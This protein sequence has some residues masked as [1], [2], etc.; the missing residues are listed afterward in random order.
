M[1]LKKI[2]QNAKNIIMLVL[3]IET[4]CDET[5][6]SLVEIYP[7]KSRKAETSGK[8][9][10]RIKVLSNVVSSQ[11]KLHAKY[12][13]VVPSLAAREHVKNLRAVLELALRTGNRK[14]KDVDLIAV[15]AG[16]GL[17][18]SLLVGTAFARTLAWKLNK[19]I[20]GVN[21]IEGHI[22]SNWL[23]PIAENSKFE[24]QN[25]KKSKTLNLKLVSD[26]G[27]RASDLFPAICLVVSGGHTQL[28]L[29]KGF[30]KYKIV[31][32]TLDDAAGEAFDKIARILG[33]G[34]PGGPAISRHAEKWKSE[35]TSIKSQTNS[36]FQ[37]P[38]IELPRPM[39]NS[40]NFDFSFSGLKTAVLYL[41][42]DLKK[43]LGKDK[44]PQELICQI[45]AEAQQ[46]I[47]DVLVSKTIKAAEEYK[48]KSI[49]LSGGV[50][51]N[52]LLRSELQKN[53]QQK[54]IKY[55]QP[56]AEYTTDNAAMIALAGY[57]KS[58]KESRQA[59]PVT[60]RKAK[61]KESW[62]KVKADAN[63]EI[64]K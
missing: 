30:R 40:K 42:R 25:S 15:T 56:F 21:H 29:M 17:I 23:P 10:D 37:I 8:S 51:A 57:I 33:L 1:K 14:L 41:D 24:I 19:P 55:F 62:Q 47:V 63:W 27:F 60:Q 36:K 20:I 38:K 44:L 26:F 58:L 45:A 6:A 7:A 39:I 16:P 4:S 12:G 11:V 43:K 32:E 34:Y 64:G 46:A 53:A 31:G 59:A 35:I 61:I 22:A 48:A 50:S 9:F 54:G 52:K 49:M 28:I 18:S 5:A 2:G 13:G 3:G